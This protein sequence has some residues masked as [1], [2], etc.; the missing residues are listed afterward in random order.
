MAQYLIAVVPAAEEVGSCAEA[1]DQVL[2]KFVELWNKALSRLCEIAEAVE[3]DQGYAALK[4]AEP[5]NA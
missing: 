2:N 5:A 1:G 3:T 4:I